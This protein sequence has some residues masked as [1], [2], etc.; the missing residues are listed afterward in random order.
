MPRTVSP[1]KR[2]APL[3]PSLGDEDAD[4]V[5]ALQQASVAFNFRMTQA[6]DSLR[7]SSAASAR[8]VRYFEHLFYT[9]REKLNSILRGLLR[10]KKKARDEGRDIKQFEGEMARQWLEG[11]IV[12]AVEKQFEKLWSRNRERMRDSGATITTA[13]TMTMTRT[14]VASTQYGTALPNELEEEEDRDHSLHDHILFS[15][16]KRLSLTLDSLSRSSSLNITTKG[17]RSRVSLLR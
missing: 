7:T 13:T 16:Q 4:P 3:L 8:F 10:K 15:F 11:E 17:P 14:S 12:K 2:P 6:V 5:Q 1:P 9:D